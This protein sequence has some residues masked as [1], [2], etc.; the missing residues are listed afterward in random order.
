VK[1]GREQSICHG[2]PIQRDVPDRQSE[3]NVAVIE[4]VAQQLLKMR[5]SS[6]KVRICQVQPTLPLNLGLWPTESRGSIE[7]DHRSREISLQR[8]LPCSQ[9]GDLSILGIS[10]LQFVEHWAGSVLAD[11]RSDSL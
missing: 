2:E 5:F 1:E 6:P 9:E 3:P 10:R 8:E 7:A 4:I 11:K